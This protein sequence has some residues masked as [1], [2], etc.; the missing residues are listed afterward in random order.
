MGQGYPQASSLESIL[1]VRCTCIHGR[2]WRCTKGRLRTKGNLEEMSH[3]SDLNHHEG[4]TFSESTH[5]SI[6]RYCT[7]LPPNKHFPCFSFHLCGNSFLQSERARALSLA[8]GLV[9]RIWHSQCF[10]LTSVSGY[11]PKLCFKP[12]KS[13]RRRGWQRMRWLDGITDSMDMG[14]SKLQEL[15]M[16]REAWHV[17]V[18]GVSKSRTWLSN[19]TE[20][21]QLLR[22]KT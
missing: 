8:T 14:L 19:W 17:A 13:R 4:G 1:A 22:K 11:K 18:H 5:V 15:V 2:M 21:I 20:L 10:G 16:D 7:L 3:I 12:L 9:A 6:H